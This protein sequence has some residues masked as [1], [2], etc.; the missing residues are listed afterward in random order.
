MKM[1]TAEKTERRLARNASKA[2]IEAARNI[3]QSALALNRCPDCGRA[4][5]RNLALTGWVQCSQYGAEG[6]RAD[7]TQPACSWQ[8]FTR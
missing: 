8:G 4:V 6:F 2:R 3:A 5:K 1:T 7:S